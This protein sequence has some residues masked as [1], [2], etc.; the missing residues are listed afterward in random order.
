MLLDLSSFAICAR[1]GDVLHNFFVSS[2]VV[3]PEEI[4]IT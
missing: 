2:L 1:R 3:D 4:K